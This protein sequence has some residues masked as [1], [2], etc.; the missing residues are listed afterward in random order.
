MIYNIEA[1][2]P[3]NFK[4]DGIVH[5]QMGI[6]LAVNITKIR[7]IINNL[8]KPNKVRKNTRIKL[9]STLALPVLDH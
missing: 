2:K 9:H 1:Q 6:N 3:S 4:S 7:G 5:I 8:F